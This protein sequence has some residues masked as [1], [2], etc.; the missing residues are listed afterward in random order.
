MIQSACISTSCPTCRLQEAL[1]IET[2]DTRAV[3]RFGIIDSLLAIP[4]QLAK[5]LETNTNKPYLLPISA[6]FWQ[7]WP[8]RLSGTQ[9]FCPLGNGSFQSRRQKLGDLDLVETAKLQHHFPNRLTWFC[10]DEM[11]WSS[12]HQSKVD[13]S[14]WIQSIGLEFPEDNKNPFFQNMQL[15]SHQEISAI[16]RLTVLWT[17]DIGCFWKPFHLSQWKSPA[18]YH[19]RSSQWKSPASSHCRN[20]MGQST[21]QYSFQV[22]KLGAR[23]IYKA[24]VRPM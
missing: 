10:F 3:G 11:Q 15:L 18:Q 5:G 20:P 9:E 14:M 24:Y 1:P 6:T 7:V 12:N 21:Y 8:D 22:P 23:T 4:I 13:L 17:K 16:F 19:Q 2:G